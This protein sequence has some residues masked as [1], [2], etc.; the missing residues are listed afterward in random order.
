MG[1][2]N[3]GKVGF[4]SYVPGFEAVL[5][6][7]FPVIGDILVGMMDQITQLPVLEINDLLSAAIR[8]SKK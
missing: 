4:C 8:M 1:D 3:D 5:V 6:K 2:R 7:K